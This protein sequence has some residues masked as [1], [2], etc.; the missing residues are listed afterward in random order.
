[1]GK[2][3]PIARLKLNELVLEVMLKENIP[4]QGDRQYLTS[5]IEVF[6]R[7]ELTR[8]AI[9]PSLRWISRKFRL[10]ALTFKELRVTKLLVPNLCHE[11][12]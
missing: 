1:M 12:Y 11:T 4:S 3:C 7:S 5:V 9:E 2:Q 8:H 10:A 6:I